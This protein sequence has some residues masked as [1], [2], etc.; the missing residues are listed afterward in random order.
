MFQAFSFFTFFSGKNQT[1][2]SCVLSTAS[3]PQVLSFAASLST[4]GKHPTERKPSSPKTSSSQIP[5]FSTPQTLSALVVLR[6]SGKSHQFKDTYAIF[7]Q[8]LSVEC[9][10]SLHAAAKGRQSPICMLK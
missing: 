2:I 9:N 10:F 5:P 6:G 7:E 1:P 4:K 3:A 8:W